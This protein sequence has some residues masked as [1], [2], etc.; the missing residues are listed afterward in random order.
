LDNPPFYGAAKAA[1]V[2]FTRYAA[3]QLAP[4]RIRVNAISPGCFPPAKIVAEQPSFIQRLQRHIPMRR[5]GSPGELVGPLLF[6]ASDASSYVT[7]VNLAVD[8][9]WTAW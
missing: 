8:G 1:L 9:G 6:L 3:V 5:I 4:E 7:G 2:Q